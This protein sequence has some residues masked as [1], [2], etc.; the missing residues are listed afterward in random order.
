MK[1]EETIIEEMKGGG[2]LFIFKMSII[3]YLCANP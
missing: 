3:Y 2:I 1:C